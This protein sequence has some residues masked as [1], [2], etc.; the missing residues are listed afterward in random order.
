MERSARS[1]VAG[2][3]RRQGQDAV[4]QFGL[5][6]AD[7]GVVGEVQLRLFTETLPLGSFNGRHA[8]RTDRLGAGPEPG[9]HLL[10]VEP[11]HG[12]QRRGSARGRMTNRT[13]LATSTAS[14]LHQGGH[15]ANNHYNGSAVDVART[16]RP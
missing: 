14:D 3:R 10:R 2:L 5:G 9:D 1:V 7:H 15:A 16:V 8:P 6:V 4:D 12:G 11:G 13:D